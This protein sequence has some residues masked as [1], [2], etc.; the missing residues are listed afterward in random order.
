MYAQVAPSGESL[1]GKGPPDQIVGKT[2][3]H[4]FLAAYT[5]GINLVVAVLRESVCVCVL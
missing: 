5:S 2:W 3:R 4:L 1:Q